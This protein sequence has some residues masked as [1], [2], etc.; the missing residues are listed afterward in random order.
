MEE[1][2]GIVDYEEA[3][4]ELSKNF[5]KFIQEGI[6]IAD[7]KNFK[8]Q[9][10]YENPDIIQE[11]KIKA[12]SEMFRE[13]IKN[14]IKKVTIIAE[15]IVFTE[16]LLKLDVI[17]TPLYASNPV[18]PNSSFLFF[19]SYLMTSRKREGKT[20]WIYTDEKEWDDGNYFPIFYYNIDDINLP[21][22]DALMIITV[23]DENY[24]NGVD[25]FYKV[26]LMSSQREIIEHDINLA[27]FSPHYN[28]YSTPAIGDLSIKPPEPLI[29]I[30]PVTLG[31]LKAEG[32]APRSPYIFLGPIDCWNC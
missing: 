18:F 29:P 26:R 24:E 11:I 31:V 19:K 17:G 30:S 8:L 32:L 16:D 5:T 25:Y 7:E 6:K 14:T 23:K 10:H 22:G 28:D 1:L 13:H 15:N 20:P 21:T 2:L 27:E 3:V 12:M 9:L 4:R